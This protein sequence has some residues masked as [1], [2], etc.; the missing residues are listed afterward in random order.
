MKQRVL[1][2][3]FYFSGLR[4]QVWEGFRGR[5]GLI[6]LLSVQRIRVRLAHGKG[7]LRDSELCARITPIARRTGLKLS[8]Q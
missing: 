2:E 6:F 5:S 3:P 1:N 7:D 4:V 8:N